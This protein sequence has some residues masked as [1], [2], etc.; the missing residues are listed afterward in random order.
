[1][2]P[3]DKS[4]SGGPIK[5]SGP[6]GKVELG[7][8]RDKLGEIRGDIDKATDDAKPYLMYAAVAGAVVIVALAFIAGRR[9]GRR[10][11]TWVEIKRL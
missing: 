3:K 1:M 4:S 5:G 11:A 2:S 6:D 10:K 7:D 9:M 8:I